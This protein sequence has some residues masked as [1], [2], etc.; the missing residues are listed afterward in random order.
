MVSRITRPG[1]RADAEAAA[2]IARLQ[3]DQRDGATDAALNAWLEAGAENR[4]AFERATEV[5]GIIPGAAALLGPERASAPSPRSPAP[6]RA[7]ALALAASLL[8]L[9]GTGGGWWLTSRPLHYSTERGQQEI[10]TLEDGT[11]ISLNTG[12][13]LSVRY[14]D[15]ARTVRLDQ[16]E[17]MFEVASNPGRPFIVEAGDR[18]VRALGTS[19]IV[20]RTGDDVAVVLIEGRVAVE[21]ARERAARRNAQPVLLA[22]GERLTAQADRAAA[23]DRPSIESVTAWRRGQAIFED[24]PLAEAAAEVNR[25]G[26]PRIVIGDPRVASLRVSGVFAT[27]DS[28]E[29]AQ[30][31]A[32]L[33]GLRVEREEGDLRIVR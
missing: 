17:A 16:G 30:A 4:D 31:V 14:R 26:G 21:N 18:R 6:V 29:F 2:W 11:R 19:F 3:S 7:W 24:A 28:A 1:D 10:T 9:I 25:Y 12:T 23:I 27:N 22:P 15:E 8:L 32:T 13:K 20:R 33:H 5:W